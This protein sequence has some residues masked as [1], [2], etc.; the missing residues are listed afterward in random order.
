[1]IACGSVR[2]LDVTEG[3]PADVVETF[4]GDP[5]SVDVWVFDR[6]SP[7]FTAL[8]D[9]GPVSEQERARADKLRGPGLASDLLSRR[10]AVRRV[11]AAYLRCDAGSIHIVTLPGGKPMLKPQRAD[12]WALAYSTSH[13]GDVFCVAVGT[14]SSL[15]VDVERQRDVPRALPI[16][17]RWFSRAESTWL[18]TLPADRFSGAFMR[19]WTAKEALAKRH[20]GGL[21]LMRG[22]DAPELDVNWDSAKGTLVRFEPRPGYFASL[23]STKPI[24]EVRLVSSAWQEV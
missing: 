22:G 14:A 11:L 3:S 17:M 6:G 12:A 10:A 7:A 9:L 16:A 18:R 24:E 20:A 1:M 19:V 13:S 8:G 21:R 15:G 5:R 23:A 2:T 4:R